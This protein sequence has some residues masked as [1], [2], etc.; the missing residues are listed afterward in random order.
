MINFKTEKTNNGTLII[1]K[2]CGQ[3][4]DVV[5]P[6]EIDGKK[7]SEIGEEAF[8]NCESLKNVIIS[9][10]I[11]IIGDY[12]F[13][14]CPNLESIKIPNSIE[15]MG[16]YVFAFEESYEPSTVDVFYDGTI[17]EWIEIEKY[18]L[19]YQNLQIKCSDG[20]WEEWRE[21]TVEELYSDEDDCGFDEDDCG[22]D[23]ENDFDDEEDYK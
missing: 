9:D 12:A 18:Q 16:I 21:D 14:N 1:T 2:Y 7:V 6:S 15:E 11:T 20:E 22:F 3:E 17:D 19:S 23:E 8:A 13:I 5:I 4:S 10:G